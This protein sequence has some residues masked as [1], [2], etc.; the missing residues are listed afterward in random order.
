MTG[1]GSSELGKCVSLS[2][3]VFEKVPRRQMTI[4]VV[5]VAGIK[6]LVLDLGLRGLLLVFRLLFHKFL[7]LFVFGV[8]V[9]HYLCDRVLNLILV[10]S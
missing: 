6:Y 3:H 4:L 9:R 10:N 2:E 7:C 8:A 1:A 5:C